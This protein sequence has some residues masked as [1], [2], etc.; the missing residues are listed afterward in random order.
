MLGIIELELFVL[1]TIAVVV[2]FFSYVG[3]H[4]TSTVRSSYSCSS[5]CVFSYV[6][7]H[8][9]STVHS[10]YSCSSGCIFRMLD[11]ILLVLFIRITVAVV[12][13]FFVC[14]APF[15]AQRLLTSYNTDWT[16]QMLD[17]QS[18][19]FYISGK[20]ITP[21]DSINSNNGNGK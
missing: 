21:D 14:W 8:F 15:H 1:L 12:V 10:S 3:H 2:A 20:Q 11:I 5:G 4:F 13:A 9:T 7:H 18:S 16:P 17:F 6:G 19:L